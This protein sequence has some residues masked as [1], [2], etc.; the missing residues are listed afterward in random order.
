MWEGLGQ[1]QN[2]NQERTT[3]FEV[4]S[5]KYSTQGWPGFVCFQQKD[6]RR[7]KFKVFAPCHGFKHWDLIFFFLKKKLL[8]HVVKQSY[9]VRGGVKFLF[10]S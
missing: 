8:L 7:G 9:R 10:A 6:P 2:G 1:E 3:V 4:F 5:L